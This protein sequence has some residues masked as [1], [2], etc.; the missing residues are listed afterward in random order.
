MATG[1]LVEHGDNFV[2]TVVVVDDEVTTSVLVWSFTG[3]FP[4]DDVTMHLLCRFP[5]DGFALTNRS[6]LDFVADGVI[7]LLFAEKIKVGFLI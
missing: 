6:L 5:G 4:G 7:E 2:S 3:N 1:E